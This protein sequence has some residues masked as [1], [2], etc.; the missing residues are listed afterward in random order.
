MKFSP[1]WVAAVWAAVGVAGLAGCGGEELAEPARDHSRPEVAQAPQEAEPAVQRA[2]ARST[3]Q[4]AERAETRRIAG[5][6]M[7]ADN[8]RYSAEENASYQ[9]E[10]H[11]AELEARDLDDFLRKAHRFVNTPPEGALTLTRA[12]G[13]RL[14]YDPKSGLFGVVRD[15]G[16]PRTVFRPED[17]EAY[18]A[19]QVRQNS[20]GRT[21]TARS[22]SES[23]G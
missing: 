9:Y 13:D 2:V 12:N 18:W 22:R 16:A 1:A 10:Q 20:G 14:V 11:G 4:A 7:W 15:D 23:A 8:R 21:R 6:P 3:T 17:G 19:S 5:R